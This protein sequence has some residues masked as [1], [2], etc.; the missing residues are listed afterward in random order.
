[1]EKPFNDRMINYSDI[2][3]CE[4]AQRFIEYLE[5]TPPTKAIHCHVADNPY[6]QEDIDRAKE[7]HIDFL[8][9]LYPQLKC[10][11]REELRSLNWR[12]LR[13]FLEPERKVFSTELQSV[14][15]N[16]EIYKDLLE[17]L[18]R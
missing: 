1:M 7:S 17:R 4:D 12:D 10:L 9:D 3:S 18:I 5:K 8:H 15:R 16:L 6:S 11:T 2:G 14:R 13:D